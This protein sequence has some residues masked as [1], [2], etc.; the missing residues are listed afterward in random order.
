MIHIFPIF[1]RMALKLSGNDDSDDLNRF[2][3]FSHGFGSFNKY[4][5]PKMMNLWMIQDGV[6]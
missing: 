1:A 3:I 4:I 5:W 6:L 2:R